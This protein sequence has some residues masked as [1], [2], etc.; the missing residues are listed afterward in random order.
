[1]K[2]SFSAPNQR[3]HG[4]YAYRAKY[5]NKFSRSARVRRAGNEAESKNLSV[6]FID[7]GAVVMAEAFSE[8]CM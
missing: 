2:S 6:F 5:K 3:R 8:S 7:H 4:G 1:M